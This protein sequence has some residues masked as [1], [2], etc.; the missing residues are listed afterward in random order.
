MRKLEWHCILGYVVN[1]SFP[2]RVS[3]NNEF[4]PR[5]SPNGMQM[6]NNLKYSLNLM[7][8]E[9]NKISNRPDPKIPD[10]EKYLSIIFKPTLLN[11]FNNLTFVVC[12]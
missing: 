10:N 1:C 12:L 4:A 3:F 2:P 6:P 9:I 11:L 8:S 7:A 5:N